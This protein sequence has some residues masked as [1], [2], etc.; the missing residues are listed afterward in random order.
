[1]GRALGP[2]R[3]CVGLCE[4][5]QRQAPLPSR[6][7]RPQGWVVRPVLHGAR[8]HPIDD[9]GRRAASPRSTS[10]AARL[11]G[12]AGPFDAAGGDWPAPRALCGRRS[13]GPSVMPA[14]H[15]PGRATPSDPA[16]LCSIFVGPA[17]FGTWPA[18][19]RRAPASCKAEDTSWR[20][21][22]RE[23]P[24]VEGRVSNRGTTPFPLSDAAWGSR[25]GRHRR[26][27]CARRPGTLLASPG[28]PEVSGGRS[29][30]RL[31]PA[32]IR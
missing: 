28:A 8:L 6:A 16:V 26:Q 2:P 13:N 27:R 9:S 15:P 3:P 22:G 19:G 4:W 20:R 12:Q 5:G 18:L 23:Q 30:I 10:L 1:M 29:S 24:R 32:A 7:R 17:E 14:P 25:P 21:P 11:H 31:P